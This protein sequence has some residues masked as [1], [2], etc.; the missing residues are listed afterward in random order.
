MTLKL[1]SLCSGYGGLD[2][3][4][5]SHFRNK[6][7]EVETVWFAENDKKCSEVLAHHW[8]DVP[9]YGDVTAIDWNSVPLCDILV[10][11]YPCQPF[12]HAGERRGEED[13][14]AIFEYIA[15][16]ISTLRPEWVVLENVAGHL[17]L[18]GTSVTGS[19]A[20]MG[21]DMRWGIVRASDTGAPHKRARWFCL[22]T[23]SRG[24]RHGEREND[25]G[26]G[27]SS[28]QVESEAQQQRSRQ[29]P[30][31][32][33]GETQTPTDSA[34]MGLKDVREVSGLEE[35][36]REART[37]NSFGPYE[38]AIR[39]WEQVL[40]RVA[41]D[42]TDEL[43]VS[44]RFLEWMMGLPDGWVCDAGLE[45]RTAELK[46]LGNGVVP[47]QGELALRLLDV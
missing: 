8:G 32:R 47:I 10:A 19:L 20:S 18:G 21:Y 43:G 39:R 12:S 9:N 35:E 1:A 24:Q 31:H 46:M 30:E 37:F 4:V 5:E 7:E 41:P 40:G 29:E 45:S 28:S 22:A 14:R 3:A 13:E 6:G 36:I 42:P 11:G 2:L 17:T 34:S 26:M 38:P 44:P 15:D 27:D 16:G 33:V 23:Y 25:R